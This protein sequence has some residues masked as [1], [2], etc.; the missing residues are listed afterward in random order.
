MKNRFLG[1]KM[2]SRT[3][4]DY[5]RPRKTWKTDRKPRKTRKFENLGSADGAKPLVFHLPRPG[6]RLR[7]PESKKKIKIKIIINERKKNPEKKIQHDF[8][9][10]DFFSGFELGNLNLDT[11]VI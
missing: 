8:I 9:A 11:F 3:R 10:L 2:G 7:F 5:P 1:M 6:G 4:P